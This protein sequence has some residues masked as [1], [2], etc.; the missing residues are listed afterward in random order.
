MIKPLENVDV[1]LG[2][3]FDNFYCVICVQY[4]TSKYLKELHS[5]GKLLFY[6]ENTGKKA[7][8]LCPKCGE[9]LVH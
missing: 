7:V 2:N 6:V 8:P 3:N 1:F 5:K 4:I 9:I